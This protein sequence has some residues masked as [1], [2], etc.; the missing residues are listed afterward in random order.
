MNQSI[1]LEWSEAGGK[2]SKMVGQAAY[3]DYIDP[4]F[5]TIVL[6]IIG[7][8]GNSLSLAVFSKMN[9]RIN[10]TYIYLI[11]LCIVD[12]AVILFG[13]GDLIIINYFK[14]V[15]RNQSILL[16][17]LHTFLVYT[18]THLSSFI[19]AAVSVDRAI[20]TNAINFARDYCKPRVA[21]K[22]FGLNCLLAIA[23]N[24][25]ILFYLGY[26]DNNVDYINNSTSKFTCGTQNQTIYDHF[27]GFYFEW[28]DL[29]F[30]AILPFFIM[31]FCTFLIVRVLYNSKQRLKR[32]K[33]DKTADSIKSKQPSSLN[34]K[35]S[36][37]IFAKK[38]TKKNKTM[39]LTYTLISIN[40]LF[41][42]LV[43]PLIIVRIVGLNDKNKFIKLENAFYLLSYANHSFNF[44]FYGSS[45]TVYRDS[46]RNL[47]CFARNKAA[48][49]L[50][51]AENNQNNFILKSNN[52]NTKL[53]D[54][55]LNAG[56]KTKILGNKLN[57][58]EEYDY[59]NSEI[60][61]VGKSALDKP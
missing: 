57:H 24:A 53:F 51:L 5:L 45:S 3:E 20:A 55:T 17:R 21:Y 47:F 32:L 2:S 6:F 36:S 22:I 50:V 19:L 40:V 12:L 23:V 54:K 9:L 10:S 49:H 59:L 18:C 43:S 37:K 7:V 61:E 52:P 26:E 28:M 44:I 34:I 1:L 56:G 16:C 58:D 42:C 25:H 35:K 13:L 14:I 8:F 46:I 15:L 48:K 4:N 11:L 31:A 30:Y 29:L 38:H 41:F 27:F 39:H 60:I 33:Q